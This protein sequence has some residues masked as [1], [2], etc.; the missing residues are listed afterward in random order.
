MNSRIS[1]LIPVYREPKLLE[2]IIRRLIEDSYTEKEIIVIFDGPCY[3]KD[4]IIEKFKKEVKF[5]INKENR[6]KVYSLNKAAK[7]SSGDVLVFLDNDVEIP[8]DQ[9][10]LE[11]IAREIKEADI[12]DMK[13]KV[14]R[15]SFLA[16][17]MFYEYASWNIGAWMIN[18]FVRRYPA[19]NGSAW[20]IRKGKFQLL[21][22]FRNEITEDLD[23]AAR[24]FLRK[25]K[26]KYT[27]EVGVYNH[28]SPSWRDWFAQRKRWT[29]G[30]ALWLKKYYKRLLKSLFHTPQILTPI[31]FFLSPSLLFIIL[32]F[33]LSSYSFYRVFLSLAARSG[34]VLPSLILSVLKMNIFKGFIVLIISFLVYA[35]LFFIFSKKLGFEFNLYDFFFYYF[36]YSLILLAMIFWSLIQVF[37]FNK[38]ISSSWGEI[39]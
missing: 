26:I 30:Q 28:V 9:K 13:K 15:D 3:G 1:I 17:V 35:F 5:I 20:A 34:L 23:I 10:F 7:L 8:G 22:G 16:R 12:L 25:Y 32:F 29:L 38:R 27:K 18:K 39:R 24:A 21:K 33:S 11:K 36:F 31:L 4:R 37:L 19:L 6:G 14:V 2:K